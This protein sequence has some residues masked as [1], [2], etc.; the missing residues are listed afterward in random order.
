MAKYD[1]NKPK[2]EQRPKPEEGEEL[3]CA[4]CKVTIDGL[5]I[6][7]GDCPVHG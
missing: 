3:K 5:V 4:G 1:W 6:P 7:M 2:D